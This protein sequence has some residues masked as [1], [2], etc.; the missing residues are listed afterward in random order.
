MSEGA[1]RQ[2]EPWEVR[3]ARQKEAAAEIQRQAWERAE[4]SQE[5]IARMAQSSREYVASKAAAVDAQK[6]A[7]SKTPEK[8]ALAVEKEPYVVDL[9]KTP[10]AEAGS[11]V[12]REMRDEDKARRRRV[13][14]ALELGSRVIEQTGRGD[15]L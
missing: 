14:G 11:I 4:R 5:L 12:A 7:K 10:H 8:E 3:D 2:E 15:T 1:P 13:R 9:T 6:T